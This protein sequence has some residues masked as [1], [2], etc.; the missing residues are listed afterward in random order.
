MI[1]HSIYFLDLDV[2]YQILIKNIWYIVKILILAYGMFYLLPTKLFPQEY[3]GEGMQ[4]VVFNFVYMTAYIEIVVTF[5]IFIK[6]FSLLLFI[7]MLVLTKLAILKWHYKK[8]I[9]HIFVYIKVSAMVFFLHLL[10]NKKEVSKKIVSDT[11]KWFTHKQEDMTFYSFLRASLF[12]SVFFYIIAMLMARGLLS[13]GDPM[14][15]TAQFIE[16]VGIL[17]QNTLFAD[18]KSFGADF[19]GQAI[20][21]YF[22]NLFT[23]LDQIILFSLFPI[24]IL[25][26]LYLSIYYVVRDYTHS[27]YVGLV[28]VMVH[29]LV[30]MSPLA[31]IILGK[32]FEI[33]NPQ[34]IDFHHL[35]FYAPQMSDLLTQGN[36]IGDIPYLRYVSGLAYEEA[37]VF[38]LLNAYF[39]IK[40]LD[41]KLNRYLYMYGLTLMLVFTFHGG[42]AIFLAIMSVLIAI[43]A[44]LFRK[45][46]MKLLKKGLLVVV[47]A[48][49]VGNLW[50]LSIIK[51]GIPQDFGA[52]APFIDKLLQ[53]KN[54][55]KQ[56]VTLGINS[57][58]IVH[59]TKVH[60]FLFIMVGFSFIVALFTKKRFV[61]ISILLIVTAV[62]ISYFG[63]NAG[64]P[65]LAKQ[66][67]Q[68]EYLFL[69]ITLLSS[70]YFFY[71][72]YK[73]IFWTFKKHTK[74]P[75]ILFAYVIFA[76]GLLVLP[77][78]INSDR[79]WTSLNEIEYTSIP[80]TILK[81]NDENRP[82]TWTAV[83]YVQAYAKVLNK[84]YHL[85]TQ[86]FLM[87]YSPTAHY[88]EVPTNKVYVFVENFPGNYMG[89]NEWYYRWRGDVQ[90]NIKTWVLIYSANHHN[91]KLYKNTGTVSIYEIDNQEYIDKLQEEEK[92]KNDNI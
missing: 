44:L 47:I 9:F 26:A 57:V 25:L 77:K 90:K 38:V 78:W 88:L 54:Q 32:I 63:P 56:T 23:N 1:P 71:F 11:K 92:K 61:N 15:D 35:L 74:Y 14:P 27:K 21:I 66:S 60:I 20:I 30:L 85:N 3:T 59:I 19:Y 51:F 83:A 82:F 48:T 69:S 24:L 7:F 72:F 28:A 33:S 2:I 6:A 81:I 79:F 31:N 80:E 65:L 89:L 29:G 73:P 41:T 64:L 16:W 10:D 4:K 34:I 67:R 12:V 43:N 45:I 36:N 86:N 75:I 17:Q 39:L 55:M 76:I 13:Y 22:V 68:A 52:A 40:T 62:F 87:D 42:G 37:S 84:G 18:N 58:S 91:I 50:M 70:F 46:D 5:L 49:I 8:D 53:T